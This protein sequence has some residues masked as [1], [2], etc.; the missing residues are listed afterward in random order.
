MDQTPLAR[1]VKQ[2]GGA[3]ALGRALGISSQAVSQ[4]ERVPPERVL[5]VEA[6]SG[7]SRHELRP[8]LYPPAGKET[9]T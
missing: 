6:A 9:Q 7:V 4:W 2:A 8:D 3:R 5:A 1:A